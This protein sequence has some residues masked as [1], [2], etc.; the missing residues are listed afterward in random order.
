MITKINKKEELY[1]QFTDEQIKELGIKPND[2]FTIT[3]DGDSIT[4]TP[5]KTIPFD[6]N[7]LSREVLEYLIYISCE[8]DM[9]VNDVINEILSEMVQKMREY[10]GYISKN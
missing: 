9:S 4:L 6:L 7:D 10:N 3:S 5:W 2:K 8:R 1:I